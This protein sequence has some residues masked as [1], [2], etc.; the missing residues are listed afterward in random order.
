MSREERFVRIPDVPSDLAVALR[1]S[2]AGFPLKACVAA[3]VESHDDLLL[4]IVEGAIEGLFR[5]MQRSG[6]TRR[7]REHVA[8]EL[9]SAVR[10]AVGADRQKPGAASSIKTHLPGEELDR[11]SLAAA[12]LGISTSAACRLVILSCGPEPR[13]SIATALSRK[14]RKNP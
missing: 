4:A 5:S 13:A 7:Q 14:L 2:A 1:G 9:R 12:E 11:L 3:L 10:R 6:A 8:E